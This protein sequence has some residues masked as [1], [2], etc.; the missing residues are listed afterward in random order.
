MTAEEFTKKL[1]GEGDWHFL[2]FV[3]DVLI[4]FVPIAAAEAGEDAA[5]KPVVRTHRY[6]FYHFLA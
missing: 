3:V 5:T 2:F 6:N 4:F 1:K